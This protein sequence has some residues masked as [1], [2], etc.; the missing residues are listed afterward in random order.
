MV[1][2]VFKHISSNMF[3][4]QNP[5]ID[6]SLDTH[7]FTLTLMWYS[8]QKLPISQNRLMPYAFIDDG[9]EYLLIK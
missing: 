8:K 2:E 5:I 3:V 4:V 6:T 9:S 1:S 7:S